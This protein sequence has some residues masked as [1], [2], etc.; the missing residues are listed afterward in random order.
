MA[1]LTADRGCHYEHTKGCWIATAVFSS[2]FLVLGAA[3]TFAIDCSY[4][5]EDGTYH[6]LRR[7]WSTQVWGK[8]GNFDHG[9]STTYC[10]CHPLRPPRYPDNKPRVAQKEQRGLDDAFLCIKLGMLFWNTS[11]IENFLTFSL[12]WRHWLIQEPSTKLLCTGWQHH[13]L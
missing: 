11:V 5:V 9:Q 8:T 10:T 1:Y 2:L 7:L 13:I 6:E 4:P 3:V 12:W